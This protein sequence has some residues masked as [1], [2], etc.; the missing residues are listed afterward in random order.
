MR[1]CRSFAFT[2]A[3]LTFY[4]YPADI[5]PTQGILLGRTVDRP[6]GLRRGQN[7]ATVADGGSLRDL[8][9]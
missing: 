4:H 3:F 2:G 1:T 7:L 5:T 6:L 9:R 8:H